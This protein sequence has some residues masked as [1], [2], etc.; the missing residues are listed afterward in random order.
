[1]PRSFLVKLRAKKNSAVFEDD[2]QIS[3]PGKLAS[4]RISSVCTPK[5]DF[6]QNFQIFIS[7]TVL[8]QVNY[9]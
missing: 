7:E 5:E 2:V 6:Y 4:Y 1:M 3:T 9:A 8:Q